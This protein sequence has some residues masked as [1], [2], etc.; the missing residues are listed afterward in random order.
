MSSG[1]DGLR[2]VWDSEYGVFEIMT[3]INA[4]E[5]TEIVG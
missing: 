1:E 3:M 5:W 2:A 4:L